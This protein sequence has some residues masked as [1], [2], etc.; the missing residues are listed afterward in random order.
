MGWDYARK[1]ILPGASSKVTFNGLVTSLQ[2]IL[3][4]VNNWSPTVLPT[5]EELASL[6]V[7]CNKLWD[8]DVNRLVPGKDYEIYLQRG[9]ST[10]IVTIFLYFSLLINISIIEMYDLEDTA[11]QPLFTFV[12]EKA[13]LRPTY[14]A[15][16]VLLD[17]YI[18]ITG[19]SE[20]V[21]EEEKK[22][23]INFLNLIMDTAVMQYV[24][25]V[26]IC[27]FPFHIYLYKYMPYVELSLL[28]LMEY[29]RIL[30]YSIFSSSSMLLPKWLTS[31][32]VDNNFMNDS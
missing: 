10:P 16:V 21:T 12:D 26:I 7:A 30:T 25:Q 29:Y 27:I 24:H 5:D 22:E 18:A 23:N 2:I 20:V 19:Q 13:L 32:L 1:R 31:R 17:N 15:F 14:A 6:S 11:S 9:K 8:L 28:Y 4:G 3:E